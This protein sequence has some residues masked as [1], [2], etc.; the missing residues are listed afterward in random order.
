MALPAPQ[1][2][3]TLGTALTETTDALGLGS[4][5]VATDVTSEYPV[6]IKRL[7]KVS[8]NRSLSVEG[9]MQ[10]QP[11]LVL[12]PDGDISPPVLTQLK[13]IGVKVIS[14]HQEFSVKGAERFI[15]DVAGVLQV[16][17]QGALL[18]QQMRKKLEAVHQQVK[19][20][21]KPTVKVLFIYARGAGN[22]TVAGKGS[23]MDA[24][25]Q[26]AGGRNAVQEFTQFKPYST[27]AL[28]KAN[29]DVLLLFDFGAS[30]LGGNDAIL[31]MPGVMLT[32]AG[33]NKRIVTVDGPLMINFAA[34]LPDAINDLY[35]KLYKQ[36]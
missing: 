9:L 13:K 11:D 10:F 4:Y 22:M 18:V 7:P 30:S 16:K 20:N 15:M 12:A 3:I 6:Y 29:P 5:I 27:E 26:L 32:N 36:E 34:R 17:Q 23:N 19:N 24:I 8:R 14:I 33:K 31:K 25:I 28:I 21:T 2:I 35:E 1:R